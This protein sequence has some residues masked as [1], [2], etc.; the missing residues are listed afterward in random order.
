[1]ETL[2]GEVEESSMLAVHKN[3]Q[4]TASK[5]LRETVCMTMCLSM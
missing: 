4:G 2:H 5:L 1:M 3:P